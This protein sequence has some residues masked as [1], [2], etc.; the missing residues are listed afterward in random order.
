MPRVMAVLDVMTQHAGESSQ[1]RTMTG[2]LPP[3]V[4]AMLLLSAL[5]LLPLLVLPLLERPVSDSSE[6]PDP[7]PIIDPPPLC[8][9]ACCMRR[10][11][12]SSATLM[13]VLLPIAP[14]LH[15]TR[16]TTSFAGQQR[17]HRGNPLPGPKSSD[18]KERADPARI[19]A[20]CLATDVELCTYKQI[21]SL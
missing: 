3:R 13:A 11:V 1:E 5:A 6:L 20:C 8:A 15:S 21:G 10:H 2:G 4:I 17:Y 7:D 16:R 12:A 9:M 19:R 18:N 14:N